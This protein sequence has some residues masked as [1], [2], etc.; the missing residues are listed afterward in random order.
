M[1]NHGY[2]TVKFG[3]SGAELRGIV[4]DYFRTTL[5]ESSFDLLG[6]TDLLPR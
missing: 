3:P 1:T 6:L 4:D 2:E 5:T